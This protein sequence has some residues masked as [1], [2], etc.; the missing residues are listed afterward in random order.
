MGGLHVS[1]WH[2]P[3]LERRRLPSLPRL[4][5]KWHPILVR[6]YNCSHLLL[7]S[8]HFSIDRLSTPGPS[9]CS[10]PSLRTD[11]AYEILLDRN[12]WSIE[13]GAVTSFERLLSSDPAP[14]VCLSHILPY[15]MLMG[16]FR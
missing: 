10:D 9:L 3:L 7:T 15:Y 5:S 11:A 14:E 13:A 1:L 12:S 2:C 16:G 4:I 8:I 6:R